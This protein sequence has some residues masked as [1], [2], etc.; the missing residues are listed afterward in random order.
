MVE[1]IVKFISKFFI[2]L[3][4]VMIILSFALWGIGDV[5]RGNT[6][7]TVAQVGD[8]EITQRDLDQAMQQEIARLRSVFGE[9]LNDQVLQ[10]LN[11]RQN[12]L[13]QMIN[14]HMLLQEAERLG[15]VVDKQQVIAEIKTV[16]QFQN[17]EGQFDKV[18]FQEFL[19]H[20]RQSEAAFVTQLK[21]NL[22]IGAL[23]EAVA[24]HPPIIEAQIDQLLAFEGEQRVAEYITIP[25]TAVTRVAE[26]SDTELVTYYDAEKEAFAAPEYRD[27]SYVLLDEQVVASELHIDEAVLQEAY[28]SR[29]DEFTTPELRTLLHIRFDQ[30]AEA[31]EAYAA[32]QEGKDF[33]A[34]AVEAG[35]SEEE[36]QYGKA[37]RVDLLQEF[38]DAV[39][40]L[41]KKQFSAPLTSPLGWHIFYVQD[42]TPEQQ[43][44]FT[45][46]K[47]QLAQE[48]K[49][50]QSADA[51]YTLANALEDSLAGGA[52]LEEAAATLNLPIL[53]AVAL[54]MDGK[55]QAGEA[56]ALPLQQ[57]FLQE[58]FAVPEGEISHFIQSEDGAQAFILRVDKITPPRIKAL[59][60]VK[61]L[62]TTAWKQDQKAA[63]LEELAE[64]AAEALKKGGTTLQ[65][66]ATQ[67]N[68]SVK[69]SKELTRAAARERS[70]LPLDLVD[71]LFALQKGEVSE[72]Y[73]APSGGYVIATLAEVIPADM[74]DVAAR[75]AV[76]QQ[77]RETL[78]QELLTQYMVY[79]QQRYPVDIYLESDSS[80]E[81]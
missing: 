71:A 60:E 30:E 16:P 1:K 22:A 62:V 39:F 2:H 55:S 66:Q 65:Q 29:V 44:S 63:K 10:S 3:L 4:V 51:L 41:E 32:L 18:A 59:D 31:K 6:N 77:L 53:Q 37:S 36:V 15:V 58:A 24:A 68:V 8:V 67:F 56:I 20:T 74:T 64:G 61:A 72:A 52:L 50:T 17:V 34:V 23:A 43:Q 80:T 5:F 19:R 54:G 75:R 76:R 47:D 14:E 57:R 42:I 45:A 69:R 48:L 25:E 40:G 21:D 13:L 70:A 9:A 27:V 11:L 35:Q 33:V 46:V 26:P 73:A 7:A 38:S 81:G 28:E 12:V 78:S 79:L 49:E